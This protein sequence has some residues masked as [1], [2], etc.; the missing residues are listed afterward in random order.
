MDVFIEK[1]VTKQNTLEDYLFKAGIISIG[2]IIVVMSFLIASIR[3]YSPF[4]LGIVGFGLYYFITLRNIEFEYSLT[5]GELDIDRIVAQRKRKRI[6]SAH[7]KEF[8]VVARLDSS[9]YNRQAQGVKKRF[10]M[11]SS[12]SSPDVYFAIL[13]YKG[14]KSV[15]FFEPNERMLKAFKTYIPKKVII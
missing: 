2:T 11:V 4:I 3:S 10:E 1:L 15:M 13:N 8:D 7:C 6:F 5:N 9:E 14:A 12:M